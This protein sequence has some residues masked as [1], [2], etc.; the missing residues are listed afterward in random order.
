MLARP[1]RAEKGRLGHNVWYEGGG[2]TEPLCKRPK[3]AGGLE[4][5]VSLKLRLTHV[6]FVLEGELA[7]G[8]VA[9]EVGCSLTWRQSVEERW[10]RD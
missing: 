1:P 2:R 5:Q 7:R 6:S 9:V 4:N 8:A 10:Q 3:H